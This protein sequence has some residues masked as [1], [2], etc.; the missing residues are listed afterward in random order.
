MTRIRLCMAL[1]IS[2]LIAF[3]F[4]VSAQEMRVGAGVGFTLSK[5]QLGT[6]VQYRHISPVEN[7]KALLWQSQVEYGIFKWLDA[8]LSYRYAGTFDGNQ[9][10]SNRIDYDARNRFTTDL[11]LKTQRFDNDVKLKNRVRYQVSV[12]EGG[13]TKNYLRN[14][15]SIDYKLT[16]L[17]R[18][19][20]DLEVYYNIREEQFQSVRLNLGSSW[21]LHKHVVDVA[22]I[23]EADWS[24]YFQMNYVLELTYTFDW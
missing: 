14:K 23:A 3:S 13:K 18:P 20:A 5:F 2:Q 10:L 22:A 8:G 11:Q 6:E 15:F 7:Q 19:F 1:V 17:F 24:D 21:V 9:K 12:K 4:S 16:S